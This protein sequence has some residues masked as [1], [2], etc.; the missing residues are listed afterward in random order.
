[1]TTGRINQVPN[2]SLPRRPHATAPVGRDAKPPERRGPPRGGE[3]RGSVV[4]QGRGETYTASPG[5][6]APATHRKDPRNHPI[7]PT[8]IPQSVN[9]PQNTTGDCRIRHRWAAAY[10]PQE[11]DAPRGQRRQ[12]A[13][14]ADDFPPGIR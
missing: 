9:P 3:A 13:A 4:A 11:E 6:G 5:P 1:M 14:P 7:A 10:A 2:T 8:E 12:A